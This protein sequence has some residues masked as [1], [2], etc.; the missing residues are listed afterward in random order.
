MLYS[1]SL[2][3]H[4]NIVALPSISF[5]NFLMLSFSFSFTN[6]I[7]LAPLIP[8]HLNILHL[9]S[10]SIFWFSSLFLSVGHIFPGP[11]EYPFFVVQ[12]CYSVVVRT[13]PL[14]A[15]TCYE[16]V[17]HDYTLVIFGEPSFVPE[18]GLVAFVDLFWFSFC[19]YF[20]SAVAPGLSSASLF[21]PL[22]PS[23]CSV[24]SICTSISTPSS[25][26]FSKSLPVTLVRSSCPTLSS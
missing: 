2:F 10:F 7:R 17:F 8:L 12:V 16:K 1:Y 20:F 26:S 5:L 18:G 14:K 25:S 4:V 19:L 13:D 6:V 21:L 3:P 9:Y 23:T 15:L 24:V 11:L 22:L